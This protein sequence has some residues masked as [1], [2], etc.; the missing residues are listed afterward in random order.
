MVRKMKT[1]NIHIIIIIVL[2]VLIILYWLF[3]SIKHTFH[4]SFTTID[5]KNNYI[6]DKDKIKNNSFIATRDEKDIDTCKKNCNSIT[7]CIAVDAVK[8]N[9]L[10]SCNYYISPESLKNFIYIYFN[11]NP[12]NYLKKVPEGTIFFKNNN[13]IL[14]KNNFNILS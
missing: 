3:T 10:Y 11:Q 12:D 8:N 5:Y 6:I 9:S 13:N 7:S 2:I 4:E 1:E 14:D